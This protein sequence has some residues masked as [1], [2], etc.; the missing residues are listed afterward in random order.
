MA[1]FRFLITR[2][3]RLQLTPHYKQNEWYNTLHIADIQRIPHINNHKAQH[4]GTKQ[5]TQIEHD[6]RTPQQNGSHLHSTAL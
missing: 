6:Y 5:I 4:R 2:T 1:A 3:L